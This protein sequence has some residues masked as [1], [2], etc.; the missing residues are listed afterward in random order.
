[1]KRDKD[2]T[3][4]ALLGP[5]RFDWVNLFEPKLNTIKTPPA[6]EYSCVVLLPKEDNEFKVNASEES[7]QFK[8]MIL[9]I[10]HDKF[11]KT[12]PKGMKMLLKDGDKEGDNGEPGAYPG[13]WH[14]RV[15]AKEEYAPK[16]IDGARNPISEG[17]GSGD[18]GFIKLALFAY[19]MPVNKGV[20]AGIRAVQFTKHDEPFG[21]AGG[22]SVD[23]FPVV[24]VEKP[25]SISSENLGEV[26]P[27]YDP[28]AEVDDDPFQ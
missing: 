10:A 8:A 6:M 13:Y 4:Q 25:R 17:W 2:Y 26:D 22:T 19:D 3:N 11:G 21:S 5:V 9:E 18:W 27:N 20:S 24:P 15:T 12:L 7:T 14:M 23:D 28:H 16:I 1:M